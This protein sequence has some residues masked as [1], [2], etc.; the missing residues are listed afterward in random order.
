MGAG[1]GRSWAAAPRREGG[2]PVGASSVQGVSHTGC[3]MRA[4]LRARGGQSGGC[5]PWR[6]PSG[7]VLFLFAQF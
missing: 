2:S 3:G 6:L 7:Q 4:Q 5:G 1:R